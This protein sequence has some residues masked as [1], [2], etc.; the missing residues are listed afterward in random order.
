MNNDAT[1]LLNLDENNTSGEKI[2][3]ITLEKLMKDNNIEYIDLMQ[4]NIEGWEYPILEDWIKTGLIH[5]IKTLQ[6]QFHPFEGVEDPIGRRT[7]IQDSLA[8]LGYRI[9]LK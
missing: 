1:D 8:S 7:K 6:I 2:Q 9:K 5:K 3:I 4:I